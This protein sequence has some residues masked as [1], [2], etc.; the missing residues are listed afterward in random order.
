MTNKDHFFAVH[1]CVECGVDSSAWDAVNVLLEFVF[2]AY[3]VLLGLR[4]NECHGE[5][6]CQNN[7]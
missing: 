3:T 2:V 1:V 6:R 4:G 7:K 5:L